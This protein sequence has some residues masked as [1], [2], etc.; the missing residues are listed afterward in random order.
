MYKG[1]IVEQGPA[2]DVFGRP[3]HDYTQKLLAAVP[4]P[5][6]QHG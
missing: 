4:Q 6:P 1:K 3:R 5:D 2:A